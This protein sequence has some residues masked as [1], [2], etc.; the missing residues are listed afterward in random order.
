MSKLFI[1]M[2][3]IITSLTS[4]ASKGFVIEPVNSNGEVFGIS[5]GVYQGSGVLYATKFYIPDLSYTSVRTIKNGI[6]MA[7]TKATILGMKVGGAQARLKVVPT[8]D[9]KFELLDLDNSLAKV[10]FGE[11]FQDQ[12]KFDATV[13]GGE[14]RLKETWQIDRDSFEITEGFQ[15]MKGAKST[16]NGVFNRVN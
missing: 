4:F 6:I 1:T 10:G 12:C 11:C 8:V 5:P 16:Y 14:L 15:N 9:G 2:V 13:M 3:L 7:K